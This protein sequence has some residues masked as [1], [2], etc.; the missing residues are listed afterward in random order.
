MKQKILYE[1]LIGET[2]S[3]NQREKAPSDFKKVLLITMEVGVTSG[4][5]NDLLVLKWDCHAGK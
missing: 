4:I 5:S 2:L 1:K 3:Y